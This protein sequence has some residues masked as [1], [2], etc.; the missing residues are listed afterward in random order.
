[1]SETDGHAVTTVGVAGAG[2]E[3]IADLVA[4]A[5]GD[6][7]VGDPESVLDA[8]PDAAVALGE[9]AVTALATRAPDLPVLTV[10]GPAG[11]LSVPSDAAPDAIERLLD[12]EWTAHGRTLLDVVVG[13]SDTPAASSPSSA[14]SAP[15]ASATALLDITLMTAEPAR[16]SEYA[17]EASAGAPDAFRA[18][19]VAVAT[20]AG[21]GGYAR[22]AGG[23]SLSPAVGG[24]VVVPVAPFA[25]DQA[26]WVLEYPLTLSVERDDFPVELFVDGER[27][28]EVTTDTPVSVRRAGTATFVGVPERTPF[29]G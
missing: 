23:P 11:L 4:A 25:I 18:D 14:A 17:V 15:A 2:A 10:D 28:Q 19:G 12:G 29:F 3:S 5:G 21:S 27:L 6:P 9:G 1:M 8:E 26:R 24:A 16:I 20:P 13:G 22:N 7:V